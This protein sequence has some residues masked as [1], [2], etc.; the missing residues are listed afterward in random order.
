MQEKGLNDKCPTS[1]SMKYKLDYWF[2][3]INTL[4]QAQNTVHTMDIFL[5]LGT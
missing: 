5:Q 1:L 3:Q 2:W 4:E